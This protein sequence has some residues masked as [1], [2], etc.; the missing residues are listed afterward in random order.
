MK[1]TIV[2]LGSV[3]LM[4][5]LSLSSCTG[6]HDRS[7]K[8]GSEE[9]GSAKEGVTLLLKDADII[10]VDSHPQYNTAEWRFEVKKPGRYDIWLSS[11]TCDTTHILFAGNV[12]VTAGDKRLEKRPVG[13]EIVTDDKNV[14]SPWFRA[15]SHMGSVLFSEPGE[16]QVQVISDRIMPHQSAD[17]AKERKLTLINSLI[18]KPRVN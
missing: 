15:D 13:D 17:E 5:I 14:K 8:A 1:A 10:Q 4:L 6:G 3:S 16:Y 2:K 11:L 12:T 9:K 18:L 7:G